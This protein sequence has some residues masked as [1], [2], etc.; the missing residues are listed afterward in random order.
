MFSYFYQAEIMSKNPS[1]NTFNRIKFGHGVIEDI[2]DTQPVVPVTVNF[3]Q[4]AV[5][6]TVNYCLTPE[7]KVMVYFECMIPNLD[8]LNLFV[9]PTGLVNTHDIG[10]L[11][12][13]GTR[14]IFKMKLLSVSICSNPADQSLTKIE[15]E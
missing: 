6:K 12:E 9:V 13:D 8:E 4:E 15:K 2:I 14:T 7:G 10:S 1:E 3:K 5:G 11:D